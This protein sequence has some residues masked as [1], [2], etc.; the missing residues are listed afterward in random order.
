MH[1]SLNHLRHSKNQGLLS[2]FTL[3]LPFSENRSTCEEEVLTLLQDSGRRISPQVSGPSLMSQKELLGNSTGPVVVTPGFNPGF[4]PCE[5]CEL[6]ILWSLGKQQ[7]ARSS[8]LTLTMAQTTVSPPL[9]VS[10]GNT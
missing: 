2:A 8:V 3:F 9:K 7:W 4:A 6:F 10:E 1:F 5:V